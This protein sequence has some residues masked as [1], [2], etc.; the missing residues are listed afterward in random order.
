MDVGYPLD[1]TRWKGQRLSRPK[2]LLMSRPSKAFLGRGEGMTISPVA[3]QYFRHGGH[4]KPDFLAPSSATFQSCWAR[5]SLPE[6]SAVLVQAHERKSSTPHKVSWGTS[7]WVVF[8]MR[9]PDP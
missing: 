2:A 4:A 3:T 7:S 9:T 6:A 8:L 5:P 1:V